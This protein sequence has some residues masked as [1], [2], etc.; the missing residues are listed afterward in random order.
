[1]E[2]SCCPLADDPAGQA[3]R[4][5]PCTVPFPALVGAAPAAAAAGL[6]LIWI[7]AHG[8]AAAIHAAGDRG[9]Q[10]GESLFVA[11]LPLVG[12][13]AVGSVGSGVGHGSGGVVS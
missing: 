7:S 6:D 9:Q 4:A 3:N 13:G 2:C 10:A 12:G 11:A 1:M 5:H 8:P